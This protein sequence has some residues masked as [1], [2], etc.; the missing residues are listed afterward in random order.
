LD[1]FYITDLVSDKMER[2]NGK[3]KNVCFHQCSRQSKHNVKFSTTDKTK[4]AQ[5]YMQENFTFYTAS[6]TEKLK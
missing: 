2:E 1:I 3:D 4:G 6:W 5:K